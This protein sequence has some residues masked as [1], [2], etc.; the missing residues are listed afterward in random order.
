MTDPDDPFAILGE[1]VR[2]FEDLHIPYLVGGS[3]ASSVHGEP[4]FTRDIDLV[5]DIGEAQVSPLVTALAEQFYADEDLFRA[6]L[7]RQDCVN[8]IHLA[9]AYK[10]DIFFPGEDGWG[11]QQLSRRVRVEMGSQEYYVASA[12]DMILQKL[13]WYRLGGEVS[14]NQWRDV[15]GILRVQVNTL[16]RNYLNRWATE[17]QLMDLLERA[18]GE[19]GI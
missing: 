7:T 17:L 15:Q 8:I 19:A 9:A 2:V 16:D 13:R 4:R 3:M 5:A 6:A 1:V 11:Q 18:I 10:I 14:D 12:E